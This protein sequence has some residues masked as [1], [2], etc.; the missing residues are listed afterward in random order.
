MNCGRKNVAA[1]MSATAKFMRRKLIEV[2]GEISEID[3][4]ITDLLQIH[5]TILQANNEM[6]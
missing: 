2:L 4:F 5:S 3:L 6:K 1:V